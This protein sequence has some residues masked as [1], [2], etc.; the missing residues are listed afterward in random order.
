MWAILGVESREQVKIKS[1]FPNECFQLVVSHSEVE[2]WGGD[3]LG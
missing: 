2:R 3:E 1:G